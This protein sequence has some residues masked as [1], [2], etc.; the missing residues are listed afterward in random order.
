[1]TLSLTLA[2]ACTKD[3][4]PVDSDP[5]VVDTAADCEDP[6]T[7]NI[8]HDGD[9]FGSTAY[10]VQSCDGAPSGYVED[11]S[12]CDDLEA[13]VFPGAEEACN[14]VDDDCDGE[15]D[16]DLELTTFYADEDGDGFGASTNTGQF[17][18]AAEGWTADASD[19]DDGDAE[20][21]PA[22]E[23]VCGDGVDNDCDGTAG[24]CGLGDEVGVGE[25]RTTIRGEAAGDQFGSPVRNVGDLSANG[26][27]E[28]AVGARGSD[29]GADGAGAIYLFGLPAAPGTVEAADADAVLL[30]EA[31][32]DQAFPVV[33]LGDSNG[34]GIGDLMVGA[35][36]NDDGGTDAG[37]IY[38]LQ[39]PFSGERS[40]ADA[41]ASWR[42]VGA[43]D[44]TGVMSVGDLDGDGSMD[45]M[46]AAQKNDNGG[47][48]AGAV[49]VLN[50]PFGAWMGDRGL[51]SADAMLRGNA[52][53]Q[54][55]GGLSFAGDV[56]GD[57]FGDVLVGAPYQRVGGEEDG[58]GVYLLHGPV[59]GL[60]DLDLYADAH[61]TA[62]SGGDQV[63][64]GLASAGD[65]DGDGRDDFLVNAQREDSG[66]DN[67]NEGAV[68]LVTGDWSGTEGGVDLDETFLEIRG[69]N[70]ED[71]LATVNGGGDLDGDG[72]IDLVVA[73]RFYDGGGADA[74][75]AWVI[76]GPLSGGAVELGELATSR[77]DGKSDGDGLGAPAGLY[78]DE[79]GDGYDELAIGARWNDD[80][81]EDAGAAYLFRGSGL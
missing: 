38:F 56:D 5:V 28:L 37:K 16:E 68:Y 19:C 47:E 70:A 42:G 20:V 63:G 8:D 76:Y 77:V 7:Y 48:D 11:D 9:G 10:Q 59:T 31:E 46:V 26:L 2:L 14:G 75:A 62:N 79:N 58:G 78:A 41:E 13:G 3:P 71:K 60:I 72:H 51:Y 66:D 24:P 29:R 44:Q 65:V 23:E 18:E 36:K 57:G 64:W 73:S 74:G 39:G 34:D 43:G 21:S 32:G 33:G 1:M 6:V 35:K 50:G 80:A 67:N 27:D 69:T 25:A 54:A 81:D 17:C 15:A 4:A 61:F 55:G 30:G 40:L 52:G 53:E 22:A 49:F 12:D 45:V